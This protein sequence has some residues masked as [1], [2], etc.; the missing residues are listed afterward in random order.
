M[1]CV[2]PLL[3]YAAQLGFGGHAVF[4]T[5]EEH[6]ENRQQFARVLDWSFIALMA[7]YIPCAVFGYLSYGSHTMTPI[8]KNLPTEGH[9]GRIVVGKTSSTPLTLDKESAMILIALHVLCAYPV[10]KCAVLW[11]DFSQPNYTLQIRHMST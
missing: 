9:E 7:M 6:M 8:L 4:P 5:L 3:T 10:G 2:L 1:C 11:C